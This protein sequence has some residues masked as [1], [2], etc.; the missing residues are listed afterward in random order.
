MDLPAV[1]LLSVAEQL[2]RSASFAHRPDTR[3]HILEIAA[4]YHARALLARIS[5]QLGTARARRRQGDASEWT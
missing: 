5:T 4:D 3:S 2:E 1:D